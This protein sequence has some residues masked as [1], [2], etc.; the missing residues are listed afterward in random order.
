MGWGEKITRTLSP[1]DFHHIVVVLQNNGVVLTWIRDIIFVKGI[2]EIGYKTFHN[3]L[4]EDHQHS[5]HAL[6]KLSEEETA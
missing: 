6:D 4:A 5:R 1:P 3:S 2:E